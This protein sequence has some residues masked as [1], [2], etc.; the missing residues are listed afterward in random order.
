[1]ERKYLFDQVVDDYA[2]A[3]P[4]YPQQLIDDFWQ[5]SQL[6]NPVKVLEIGSGTGQATDLLLKNKMSVS[7][8]EIGEK[9]IA[10][11]RQRFADNPNIS[12]N[13]MPFESFDAPAKS[14]DLIF[15]ASSFHW[16]DPELAY[17]KAH[18]LLKDDG[19][20]LLCWNSK[21]DQSNDTVLFKE[22]AKV[23]A[24]IA[25][26]MSKTN[27]RMFQHEKRIEDITKEGLFTYPLYLVYPYERVLNAEEYVRLLGTYSDH[28]ALDSE[29]RESLFSSI[30][31]LIRQ[32]NNEILLK[33]EVK[34]YLSKKR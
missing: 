26:E 19:Y 24:Q 32:N 34:T 10:Y 27:Q 14:Y 16:L 3:R 7:I 9:M 15:A 30:Q 21:T 4:D 23:Y 17:K 11:L 31:D 5:I 2:N 20:L 33:Y 13:H 22:I 29:K 12:Y 25:P 28:I 6:N 18:S 8:V 1:M